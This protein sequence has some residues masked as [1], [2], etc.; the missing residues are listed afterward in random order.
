MHGT[1]KKSQSHPIIIEKNIYIFVSVYSTSAWDLEKNQS[2]LDLHQKKI[3]TAT[4]V[5]MTWKQIN[6]TRPSPKKNPNYSTTMVHGNQKKLNWHS[7]PTEKNVYV[8]FRL[9][10]CYDTW[11]L[12]KE[13]ISLDHDRKKH[14]FVSNCST[15]VV[16]RT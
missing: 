14:I 15:T 5:Q 1:N 7:I 12:K 13:S 9:Q 16:H 6:Q 4:M 3:L 2:T 10:Y 11:D 8:R